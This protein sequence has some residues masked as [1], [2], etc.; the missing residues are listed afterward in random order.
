[1]LDSYEEYVLKSVYKVTLNNCSHEIS[2]WVG[3]G[4]EPERWIISYACFHQH[5][6]ENHWNI[7]VNI[8]SKDIWSLWH[9]LSNQ[10]CY[11]LSHDLLFCKESDEVKDRGDA[12]DSIAYNGDNNVQSSLV[13]D[14]PDWDSDNETSCRMVPKKQSPKTQKHIPAS[15]HDLETR[16]EILPQA[17]WHV[18]SV[19]CQQSLYKCLGDKARSDDKAKT[20][21]S[22]IYTLSMIMAKTWRC[23]ALEDIKQ[24]IAIIS[25]LW[26]CIIFEFWIVLRCMEVKL[27]QRIIYIVIMRVSHQ[28]GQTMMHLSFSRL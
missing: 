12:T 3:N 13:C 5:L 23:I 27:M 9:A 21:C 10:H 18:K 28:K 24:V 6:K 8:P 11:N 26:V 25:L 2:K 19:H 1:M 14:P 22:K 20:P 17:A 15:L 4:S 16:E 7:V